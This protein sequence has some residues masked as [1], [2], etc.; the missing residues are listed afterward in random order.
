PTLRHLVAEFRRQL[1][2]A[3][4]R[5]GDFRSVVDGLRPHTQALWRGLS[6]ADRA[7]FLRHVQPLWDVHRHRMAPAPADPV[8]RLR[9]SGVLTVTAGTVESLE[10]TGDGVEARIRPRGATEAVVVAAR[11]VVD[12]TGPVPL[13]RTAHPLL[14]RLL[15]TRLV[16]ADALGLGLDA[17]R[18]GR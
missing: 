5:G 18:D 9:A 3:R 15:A 2:R 7:R 17:T 10:E 16:R 1:Y 12:C 8:R 11:H 14:R 4:A 6:A 13:H